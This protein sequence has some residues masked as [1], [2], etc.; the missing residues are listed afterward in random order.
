MGGSGISR[1]ESLE[2]IEDNL[3]VF[4]KPPDG[5]GVPV[6]SEG[7]IDTKLMSISNY[8]IAKLCPDTIKHLEFVICTLKIHFLNVLTGTGYKKVVMRC[9]ANITP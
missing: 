8:F 9:N 6:L 7:N 4:F 3:R 2:D 5:I 1:E